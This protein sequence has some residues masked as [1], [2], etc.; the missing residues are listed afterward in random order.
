MI[1]RKTRKGPK[2]ETFDELMRQKLIYIGNKPISIEFLMSMQLRY[3]ITQL[4]R[5]LFCYA[6]P[7][8]KELKDFGDC[9]VLRA[10]EVLTTPATV[11][12]RAELID[13]LN[14]FGRRQSRDID[15]LL[16]EYENTPNY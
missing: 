11:E 14:G 2:I 3:V 16:D 12:A 8:G 15:D 6:M 1:K 4:K 10:E 7:F 5:G 13:N 9:G